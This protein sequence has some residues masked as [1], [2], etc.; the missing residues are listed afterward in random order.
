MAN[1]HKWQ[2]RALAYDRHVQSR[3][4]ETAL[5]V[6][7]VL[8]AEFATAVNESLQQRIIAVNAILDDEIRKI[9][10]AQAS[11][12]HIESTHMRRVLSMINEADMLLRR[13]AGMATSFRSATAE[14]D[15]AETPV[16]YIGGD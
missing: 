1:R 4:I 12:K 7:E 11:G 15:E 10:E 8:L 9:R 5:T 14:Q 16:Y 3:E 13:S 6:R 2:E